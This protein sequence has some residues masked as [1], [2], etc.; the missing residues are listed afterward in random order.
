MGCMEATNT[1]TVDSLIQSGWVIQEVEQIRVSAVRADGKR[2]R[3]AWM[4]MIAA[5][6]WRR[7]AV[8]RPRLHPRVLW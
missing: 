6:Q 3:V 8:G 7:R 4:H 2:Y 5:G 1:V